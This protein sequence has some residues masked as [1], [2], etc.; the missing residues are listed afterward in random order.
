MI[1]PDFIVGVNQQKLV[2]QV[3]YDPFPPKEKPE[4]NETWPNERA[5]YLKSQYN[6]FPSEFTNFQMNFNGQQMRIDVKTTYSVPHQ[7]C[8]KNCKSCATHCYYTYTYYA[9]TSACFAYDGVEITPCFGT[10]YEITYKEY[11]GS[12]KINFFNKK[13]LPYCS[14]ELRSKQDPKLGL[15]RITNGSYIFS[16]S[17]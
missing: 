8:Y 13:V 10:E 3:E 2:F 15:Y 1:K 6:K 12:G 17:S 7:H 4:Q 16:P 11:F 5:Y 9:L 14:V